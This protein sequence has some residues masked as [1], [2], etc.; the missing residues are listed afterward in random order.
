VPGFG[1]SSVDVPRTG[2]FYHLR[3]GHPAPTRVGQ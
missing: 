2:A 1:G 3:E